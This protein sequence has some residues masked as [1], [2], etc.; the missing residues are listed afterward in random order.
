MKTPEVTYGF[1]SEQGKVLPSTSHYLSIRYSLILLFG[2]IILTAQSQS[3][4]CSTYLVGETVL[5]DTLPVEAS[6]IPINPDVAFRL[7][8]DHRTITFLETLTQDSVEICFRSVSEVIHQPV[9]NR[10]VNRYT[11]G[12]LRERG[13][14]LSPIK[15]E[16]DLFFRNRLAPLGRSPVESPLAIARMSLLIRLLTSK[17]KAILAKT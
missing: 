2:L 7:E 11:A 14:A 13:T 12:A 10:D 17:W 5:L 9:F 1:E 6:S 3:F 4:E 8:P 16:E 15:E